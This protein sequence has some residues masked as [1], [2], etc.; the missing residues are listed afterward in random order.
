MSV[1]THG[2]RFLLCLVLFLVIIR[3]AWIGHNEIGVAALLCI[4]YISN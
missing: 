1:M 2:R 3:A 4:F